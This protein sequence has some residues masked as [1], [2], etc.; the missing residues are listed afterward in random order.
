MKPT[1][2]AS[3]SCDRIVHAFGRRTP[4]VFVRRV[5]ARD[6][7]G[8]L[9]IS[10]RLRSHVVALELGPAHLRPLIRARRPCHSRRRSFGVRGTLWATAR[11]REPQCR[12]FRLCRLIFPV[13]TGG[14]VERLT[15]LQSPC[16][17]PPKLRQLCCP[18]P[19]LPNFLLAHKHVS[20]L[21]WM[22][23]SWPATP[24][25]QAKTAAI[26]PRGCRIPRRVCPPRGRRRREPGSRRAGPEESSDDGCGSMGWRR[27][28]LTLAASA[29][30]AV[31]GDGAV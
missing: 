24:R 22:E 18:S 23:K 6:R 4:S 14:P 2:Q 16:R 8:I 26:G 13:A 29:A 5:L 11:T 15:T 30:G 7:R 28:G 19:T 31:A 3:F 17:L 27:R 10:L 20:V 9:R 1:P 25:I 21:R 12:N